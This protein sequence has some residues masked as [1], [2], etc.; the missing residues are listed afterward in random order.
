MQPRLGGHTHHAQALIST[1]ADGKRISP[2]RSPRGSGGRRRR[3]R[4]RRRSVGRW[5]RRERGERKGGIMESGGDVR[6]ESGFYSDFRAWARESEINAFSFFPC[7]VLVSLKGFL[8]M[9][10][11]P[12]S[13]S[14]YLFFVASLLVVEFG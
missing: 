5:G 7:G 13:V 12:F 9:V 2:E 14:F 3:R 4:P 1:C 6:V 8:R 10:H 11:A